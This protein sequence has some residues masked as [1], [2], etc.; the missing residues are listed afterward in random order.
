MKRHTGFTLIELMVVVAIV[1][2][3]AM[4]AM[5]SYNDY[6]TRSRI[7]EAISRLS[8]AKVRME[9]YFQDN[10]FYNTDG[11]SGTTCGLTLTSTTYFTFSCV[12]S[13]NGQAYVWTATGQSSMTG[14]S[15]TVNQQGTATS[16]IASGAAW[17]A[18]TQ[19]TCWITS[20]SG[21]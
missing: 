20:K 2:I 4:V 21:C 12:T 19:S 9:Q 7:P 17:P 15:Y 13:N 18:S 6:M 5:P 1:G 11:G 16:A 14:F 3:L 8:D 10:R